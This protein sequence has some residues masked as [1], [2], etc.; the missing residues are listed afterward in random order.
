MPTQDIETLIKQVSRLPGLGPRSAQRVVL[1]LIQKK[2][3]LLSPL[4]KSMETAVKSVNSCGVCGN[5]DSSDPCNICSDSRRD[6]S[7]ICVVEDVSDLWALERCAFFRGVYH[8]TGGL[9]SPV[10]GIRPE[11]INIP[12]LISRASSENVKEVIMALSATIDGQTTAHY[13]AEHL[14]GISV[15]ISGIAQGVP[16]GGEINYLDDGTLS[17][18]LR[19]R[20]PFLG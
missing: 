6:H 13:L 3:S 11:D 8:V 4:M 16:V 17:E 5:F 20:R 7:T 12:N 2:D 19:S 15:S 18:A 10:K 14:Q 9:L 1:A